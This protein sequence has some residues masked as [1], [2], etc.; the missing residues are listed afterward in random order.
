MTAEKFCRV[1]KNKNAIDA[2]KCD[3][4]G[5]PFREG[6][7]EPITT[8]PVV[9]AQPDLIIK[10]SQ[11]L[12]ELAKY[13]VDALVLFIM[14]DEQPLVIRDTHK[15]VLG[16]NISNIPPVVFDL[17]RY[18]AAELGVSR[19]HAIITVAND[20]YSLTDLG[21]T[22]G[23]WLNASHLI[24]QKPYPLHSGDQV[25]LGNLKLFA[26]FRTAEVAPDA[27]EEII[28]LVEEPHLGSSP[29]PRMTARYL[30]ATIHPFLQ[31]MVDLQN[32]IEVIQ[33]QPPREVIINTISAMRQDLPLG[34]SITGAAQAIKIAKEVIVPWRKERADALTTVFANRA[35]QPFDDDPPDS[36]PRPPAAQPGPHATRIIKE[37]DIGD[38]ASKQVMNALQEDLLRLAQGIVD[39]TIS[40]LSTADRST[41]VARIMPGLRTLAV[42]RLQIALEKP[43]SAR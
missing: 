3:Y 11:Y 10:S 36:A 43:G 33:G 19:Q 13:P 20:A 24:A 42:S 30:S 34:I 16:R 5:A 12:Q 4:C 32:A 37:A 41:H 21:S 17:S 7:R 1:C 35:A 18:G 9:G 6:S 28:L 40:D 25:R 14:D 8:V 22:N 29:H 31:A 38:A 23:T 2:A 15:A 27:T 26:Y 39:A